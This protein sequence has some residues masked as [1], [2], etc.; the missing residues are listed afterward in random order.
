MSFKLKVFKKFVTYGFDFTGQNVSKT[1]PL[2]VQ[3]DRGFSG[4]KNH[5]F[6]LTVQHI[7]AEDVF[8][9]EYIT[10]LLKIR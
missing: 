7:I 2:S 4:F 10:D 3:M 6:N 8:W 9:V 5:R 1:M